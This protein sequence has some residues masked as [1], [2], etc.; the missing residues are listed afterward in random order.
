VSC[1]SWGIAVVQTTDP[2]AATPFLT[3]VWDGVAQQ[4]GALVVAAAWPISV[5]LFRRLNRR[6]EAPRLEVYLSATLDDLNPFRSAAIQAIVDTGATHLGDPAGPGIPK[7]TVD[8]REAQI[9]A[10]DLFI[11]LYGFKY[12]PR[13]TGS[14]QSI[15]E[16]ELELARKAGKASVLWR[17]PDDAAV[18]RSG[19]DRDPKNVDALRARVQAATG[20]LVVVPLPDEPDRLGAAVADEI[21]RRARALH[22]REQLRADL[23]SPAAIGLAGGLGVACALALVLRDLINGAQSNQ[24]LTVLASL[25]AFAASY[26]FRLLVL[27][28]I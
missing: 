20:H 5:W 19:Q 26:G 14:K 9:N 7:A 1:V 10:C 17:L 2:L 16:R 15:T 22:P 25:F 11:G 8:E 13:I 4:A 27:R 24:V 12:G 21:V 18:P 28:R 3:S 23:T 6:S